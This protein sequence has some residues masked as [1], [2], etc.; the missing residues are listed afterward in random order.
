V[1]GTAQKNGIVVHE[2]N[3]GTARVKRTVSVRS[4]AITPDARAAR[5]PWTS[6]APTIA[7]VYT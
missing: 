5:P 2:A 4:R 6:S 7:R 3:S 1:G